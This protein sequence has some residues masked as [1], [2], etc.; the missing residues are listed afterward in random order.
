[1]SKS[2]YASKSALWPTVRRNLQPAMLID[3]WWARACVRIRPSPGP[4]S[5]STCLKPTAVT[6][7]KM[8][9]L[10]FDMHDWLFH[11][12]AG[13]RH[14]R[15]DWSYKRRV[16]G[17]IIDADQCRSDRQHL[18]HIYTA[19]ISTSTEVYACL[20]YFFTAITY[21]LSWWKTLLHTLPSLAKLANM[22]TLGI[23]LKDKNKRLSFQEGKTWR[24]DAIAFHSA[25]NSKS[26]FLKTRCA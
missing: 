10:S 3:P 20:V 1:M 13:E 5:R 22:K 21:F 19:I 18:L 2:P 17:S 23:K 24:R 26:C 12:P 11:S 7:G 25:A 15:S 6:W 8:N 4:R 14:Q 16:C 9:R